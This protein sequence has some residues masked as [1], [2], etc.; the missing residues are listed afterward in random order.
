[1]SYKVTVKMRNDSEVDVACIIPHGQVF[2]N[3]TI[4]SGKQNLAAAREYRLII[5]AK[6]RIIAELDA[7]CVNRSFS[8]PSGTP[9]NITIF[10]IDKALS[11]QD[12]VWSTIS[13]PIH[14]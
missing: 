2:E 5:P 9:G 7:F 14:P 11:S 13:N 8:S 12:D 1:M 10:K 3:K 6:S 4:G